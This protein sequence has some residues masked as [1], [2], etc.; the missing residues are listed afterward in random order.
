MRTRI[1]RFM[2]AQFRKPHGWFGSLLFGRF[3]NRVNRKIIDS[4]IAL[5]EL[6]P[7]HH[8]LD[9]GFG[10]GVSLSR[11]ART[12]NGGLISGIDLSPDM[13]HEAERR[14]R[15]L[16]AE[17]RMR[18]QLGDVSHL[19]F[20][21]AAFDRVFTINTIYFWPDALQGL[22]EIRRVLKDT[23]RAAIAIRSGEKMGNYAV[24]KYDFRLFS[25]DDVANLMRQ[26]GFHDIRVDHRDRDRWYDQV[27]VLGTR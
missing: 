6:H 14:F 2:A 7:Q 25:P 15:R 21:D 10:G 8:V 27:I 3:M 11:L 23:G 26:A 16:I 22:G 9:I 17:G 12:V 24:T 4:T 20:P 19:P 5:L 13:V 1:Q 18:V